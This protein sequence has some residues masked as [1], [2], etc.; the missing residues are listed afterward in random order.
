MQRLLLTGIE[1]RGPP[2][3]Q[4]QTLQETECL[5][6]HA[7]L[8]ATHEEID[9]Q[10]QHGRG[11]RKQYAGEKRN[12][13]H[14]YVE[15]N[16]GQP[17]TDVRKDVH[18]HVKDDTGRGTR[19]TKRRRQLHDAVRFAAHQSERRGVVERKARH[20]EFQYPDIADRGRTFAIADETIPRRGI[21]SINHHPN[22]ND[23][24]QPITGT[25]QGCPQLP[26]ID[27]EREEHH[28]DRQ[29]AESKKPVT[30]FRGH[31]SWELR[32]ENYELILS[33]K[34]RLMRS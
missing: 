19:R 18:H 5:D 29:N 28:N 6:H 7:P 23:T 22:P 8:I 26:E 13:I 10:E 9:Q 30:Q 24:H 27:I 25:T 33:E 15:N 21:E 31:I 2:F 4:R 1:T 11:D 32:I 3:H 14:C 17:K 20:R 16:G 12:A 34:S